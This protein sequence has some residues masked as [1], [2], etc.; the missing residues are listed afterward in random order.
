MKIFK[1]VKINIENLQNVVINL[2]NQ[3]FGKLI[4]TTIAP[5]NKLLSFNTLNKA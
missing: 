3:E 5:I 4:K 2:V 1:V